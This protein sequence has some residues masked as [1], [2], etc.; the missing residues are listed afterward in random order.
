MKKIEIAVCDAD[1]D[2][3]KKAAEWMSM[4]RGGSIGA[5]WF[6]SE[7]IFGRVCREKTFDIVLLGKTFTQGSEMLRDR[8]GQNEMGQKGRQQEETG[9]NK[10]GQKGRKWEPQPLY[11]Q[12]REEGESGI[13]MW[14]ESGVCTSEES[15]GT[16]PAVEKYQ[17][18][19]SLLRQVFV[20]Y[21]EYQ[22]EYL[23]TA[24]HKAEVIGVY[25]PAKTIWQV[26]F[27]MVLAQI[28][29]GEKQVLYLNLM[30]CAAFSEWFATEYERDLLD[31]LYLLSAENGH[32]QSIVNSCVYG[33]EGFDYIPPAM[34]GHLLYEIDAGEYKK[35]I[36][37]LSAES[38]YDVLVVDFGSMLPG[39]F[40]LLNKCSRI[41][42]V[43]ESG[44]L[45]EGMQRLFQ[46]QVAR[47]G[48]EELKEKIIYLSLPQM[49]EPNIHGTQLIQQWMWSELGDYV[50]AAMGAVYGRN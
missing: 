39:F 8:T 35:Y 14:E 2:Y 20:H 7:E 5:S 24:E 37:R 32:V 47:Q 30:E 16:M 31:V 26:P 36:Q 28:L 40:E 19:P 48:K 13:C 6:S 29:G 11:I 3:G 22:K 46:M 43:N 21:Q 15:R 9:Q 50:R 34:D 12:L 10:M 44:L 18:L 17:P 23:P 33:M 1:E 25:A 27:S 38:G 4:E 41:Y 42:A 49:P 45:E